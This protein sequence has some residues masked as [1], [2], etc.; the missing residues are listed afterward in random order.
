MGRD[1][2][3]TIVI[4]TGPTASGKSQFALD[5]ALSHHGIIVNADSVQLYRDLPVLSASPSPD[6]FKK[7]QHYFYG[8][9]TPLDQWNAALWCD[10]VLNLLKTPDVQNKQLF[11]VGGTGLYLKG[12]IEGFAAIPEIHPDYRIEAAKELQRRG[13]DQFFQD[14]ALLDPKIAQRLNPRDT[15]RLMRTWEVY[16]GTGKPL[17]YWQDQPK[18]CLTKGYRFII[19]YLNPSK[20]MLVERSDQRFDQMIT[21][22]ALRE[23]Q[24]LINEN[25]SEEAPIYKTLGARPLAQY[26]KGQQSLEGATLIAK[27]STHHYIKRQQTWFRH[28]LGFCYKIDDFY[29]EDALRYGQS[30]LK[31]IN[32]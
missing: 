2:L 5:L 13:Y 15:Q 14:L 29:C 25:I 9:L 17:S 12:L 10:R 19:F 27:K 26:L 32:N 6:D 4:V 23:V 20:S 31:E 30:V 3:K 21:Q 28:Q 1:H 18:K 7:I 24:N 11:I 8:V 16:H 22:G